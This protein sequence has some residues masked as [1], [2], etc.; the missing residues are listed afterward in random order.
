VKS[1]SQ[2]IVVA[3]AVLA[4]TILLTADIAVSA[5]NKPDYNQLILQAAMGKIQGHFTSSCP[6]WQ[7]GMGR[8][9]LA[10]YKECVNSDITQAIAND[11][12]ESI[13]SVVNILIVDTG[14]VLGKSEAYYQCQQA[15]LEYSRIIL[16][17][18]ASLQIRSGLL[19]PVEQEKAKVAHSIRGP[20]TPY[21]ATLD[22]VNVDLN[23]IQS[24]CDPN[25]VKR[26]IDV[27]KSLAQI[28]APVKAARLK[29]VER[30]KAEVQSTVQPMN[31]QQAKEDKEEEDLKKRTF[32]VYEDNPELVNK[33]LGE[34]TVL[35]LSATG[36]LAGTST[37]SGGIFVIELQTG[38]LLFANEERQLDSVKAIAFNPAATKMAYSFGRKIILVDLVSGKK[39]SS[40]KEFGST[41]QIAFSPDGTS[42][43]INECRRPEQ[44]DGVCALEV[45]SLRAKWA[46][47]GHNTF[48]WLH[49][50]KQFI[51]CGRGNS[52]DGCRIYNSDNYRMQ[53]AIKGNRLFIP[54]APFVV[55]PDDKMI[56]SFANGS[57]L[58]T[59]SIETGELLSK[60]N[61]TENEN[62]YSNMQWLSVMPDGRTAVSLLM[63]D[64][65]INIDL[66]TFS[67]L[68]ETELKI[69]KNNM[70]NV[71]DWKNDKLLSISPTGETYATMLRAKRQDLDE[72][73]IQWSPTPN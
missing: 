1:F 50:G 2:I 6:Q 56:V 72:Y 49:N 67:V 48:A 10:K 38:K 51:T 13:D 4:M 42:L 71:L 32:M 3:R 45:P 24:F 8:D 27:A 58:S 61:K 25:E 21:S 29:E 17:G 41:S 68:K 40:S 70:D 15:G 44:G 39:I 53:Q 64:K 23:N 33:S 73:S 59:W 37:A 55:S 28:L 60:A 9:A 43:L 22:Q 31:E 36:K 54:S 47:N 7:L 16:T 18:I 65:V 20:L 66:E 57:V 26:F 12:K 46:A 52:T 62:P 34:P 5:E 63:S 19:F 14:I 11:E 35:T 69:Y 30:I